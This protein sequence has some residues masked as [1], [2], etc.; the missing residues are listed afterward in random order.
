MIDNWHISKLELLQSVTSSISNSGASIQWSADQTERC[1]ITEIKALSHSTNNQGYESQICHYLNRDEKCQQF[2]LA[3]AICE[4]RIDFHQLIEPGNAN[5]CNLIDDV[6]EPSDNSL[7][8]INSTSGFL[9]HIQLAAPSSG[10]IRHHVNCWNR[11]LECCCS[12][13][14]FIPDIWLDKIAFVLVIQIFKLTG[15]ELKEVGD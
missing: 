4:A 1:H 14:Y 12:G 10:M 13:S 11:H 6:G 7:V 8:A 5:D 9:S 2:N 15:L 3:T